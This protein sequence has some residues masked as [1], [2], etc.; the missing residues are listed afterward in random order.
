LARISF[1]LH[2]TS[3]RRLLERRAAPD[4]I[5]ERLAELRP[6]GE[7]ARRGARTQPKAI[8]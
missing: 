6:A 5:L 2:D 3:F 7:R 8:A 4:A 1:V